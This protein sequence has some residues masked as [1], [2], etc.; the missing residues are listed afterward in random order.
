MRRL[1]FMP[2]M[3]LVMTPMV[4]GF[5]WPTGAYIHEQWTKIEFSEKERTG[6][7][8]LEALYPALTAALN[9]RR[10]ITARSSL[11]IDAEAFERRGAAFNAAR[12]TLQRARQASFLPDDALAKRLPIS[13]PPTNKKIQWGRVRE[14]FASNTGLSRTL[15]RLAG[16]ICDDSNSTLDPEI[17]T[18]YR[19]DWICFAGPTMMVHGSAVR[20]LTTLAFSADQLGPATMR[21]LK[22]AEAGLR[23]STQRARVAATKA[24][25]RLMAGGEAEMPTHQRRWWTAQQQLIDQ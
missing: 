12:A 5:V 25:G 1:R 20:D 14:Q 8:L 22:L 21:E 23:A 18:F 7:K 11:L 9:V 4:L 19:R 3:G 15:V 16:Q 24:A 10:D 17:E 6:V 2:K 13:A